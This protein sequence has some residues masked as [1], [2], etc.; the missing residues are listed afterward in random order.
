M[1][2]AKIAWRAKLIQFFCYFH[3]AAAVR[4]HSVGLFSETII[5]QY[6]DRYEIEKQLDSLYQDLQIAHNAEEQTVC[7]TFNVD[8]RREA[9]QLITDDI[10][11]YEDMLSC[12]P[13]EEQDDGMDY[14]ALCSVQGL[15]RYA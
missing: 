12:L 14:D 7:L 3:F 1:R 8:T 6:M 9:V 2:F 15:A 13:E 10:D 5:S 11:Y 4:E